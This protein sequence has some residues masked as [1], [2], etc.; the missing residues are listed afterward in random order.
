MADEPDRISDDELLYRRI[1]VS[2]GWYDP[3]NELPPSPKA[4]RP[5][6]ARDKT[7]LS[8]FRARYVTVRDLTQN[9][10]GNRYY[11]AVLR[12]GDLRKQ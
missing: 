8:V 10:S 4:F 6:E 9:R 11:I 2:Q 12:T 7:G 3:E 1:P 5:N